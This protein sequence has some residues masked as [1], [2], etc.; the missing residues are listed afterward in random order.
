M[1]YLCDIRHVAWGK[2]EY[3]AKDVW[4]TQGSDTGHAYNMGHL[5]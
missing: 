4:M 2:M 1:G 5:V 3:G